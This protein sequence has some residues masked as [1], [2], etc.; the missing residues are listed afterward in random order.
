MCA[1]DAKQIADLTIKT[2]EAMRS[3]ENFDMFYET[4]VLKS[5]KKKVTSKPFLPRRR[6]APRYSM[7]HHLDG[8]AVNKDT[9]HPKTPK[10]L[11]R[12]KYYD[13]LDSFIVALKDKFDQDSFKVF[14]QL[15]DLLL[16]SI[17]GEDSTASLSFVKKTYKGDVDISSLETELL[18]LK[19]MF[20]DH[21]VSTFQ[22]ILKHLQSLPTHKHGLIKNV[23]TIC[24]L[25]L[26]NPTTTATA[27]RSF[28]L[29]RRLKTW[30]RSTMKQE[31]FN[32]LALL[33]EYRELT[34]QLNLHDI[35]NEFIS[36]H[37]DRYSTFGKF[38]ASDM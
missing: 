30:E 24:I 33:Q 4:T 2:I 14:A 1:L 3:E 18:I 25:L 15:E 10:D 6:N 19:T 32:S 31:R 11:Y 36:K 27:E 8:Y 38:V 13:A 34:D 5:T 16:K 9:H 28:S 21:P 29:A 22:D 26:V 37:E 35:G 17:N 7:L 12:E 20:S 23:I